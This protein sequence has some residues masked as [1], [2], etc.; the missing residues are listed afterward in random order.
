MS[1]IGIYTRPDT[2]EHKFGGGFWWFK[3]SLP[4]VKKGDR[5]WVAWGGRWQGYFTVEE[6]VQHFELD[7]G[8]EVHFAEWVEVDG[9]ERRSF[10]GFTY[11]VPGVV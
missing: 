7:Y 9:G 11:K 5:F 1:D 8:G 10:Q 6:V 4:A 2:I 3:T